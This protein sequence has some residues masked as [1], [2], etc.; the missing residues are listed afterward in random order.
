[1]I[2]MHVAEKFLR[3]L[4][5]VQR[6]SVHTV[7]AYRRDLISLA[8]QLPPEQS[9]AQLSRNQVQ[10]WM[11]RCHSQG[12]SAASL[13]RRLSALRSLLDWAER[14]GVVKQNVA[15]S[16][17]L[18]KQPKR[19]P[20]ALPP[21]QSAALFTANPNPKVAEPWQARDQT[22]VALLY[23]C[24]LRVS[25]L[26]ALNIGDL[27]LSSRQLQ[28]EEGKGNKQRLVP[29]PKQAVAMV[30]HYLQLRPL[31]AALQPAL[32]INQR[33]GRLTSRS[34]Q[35]LLK[36]IARSIGIDDAVTPHRLRHSYATDMLVGGADLRAV[37]ELLGHAS[38][39]TTERYTHLDL[40][41]LAK[42]YDQA[43][44]RAHKKIGHTTHDG[45]GD[46]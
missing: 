20:R 24:G 36:K 35:R 29:I 31:N 7:A 38:L 34:V 1:M 23:G 43:H 3:Q 4:E 26:V 28:V 13:S 44:P 33:G 15:T 40:G 16:V 45:G 10:D 8:D 25:E 41:A 5:L 27:N 32:L 18:P 12:L 46:S 37:Q 6:Y 17:P 30:R 22:M 14:E 21:D 9:I 42:V 19:L 39:A 11:V 2:L